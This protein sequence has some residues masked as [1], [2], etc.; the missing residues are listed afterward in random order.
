M[1]NESSVNNIFVLLPQDIGELPVVT[2]DMLGKRIYYSFFQAGILFLL[3]NDLVTQI[4]FF[5][6]PEEGFSIYQ[7]ELPPGIGID[8]KEKDVVEV[9]GKPPA[10]GGGKPDML[11]GY[12]NRWIKYES[13]DY[14]LHME[15]A[16]DGR[17]AKISLQA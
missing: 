4:T 8:N 12:I 17:L 11:L 3:E 5:M 13:N 10:S 6:K 9:K 2:T 14:A 15:F 1:I 16:Q 7:G